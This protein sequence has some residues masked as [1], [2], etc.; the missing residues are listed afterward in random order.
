MG[1]IESERRSR[2]EHGFFSDSDFDCL[3]FDFHRDSSHGLYYSYHYSYYSKF[4]FSDLTD[5]IDFTHSIDEDRF[6][7]A[8]VSTSISIPLDP[9]F[10]P[11]AFRGSSSD[12]RIDTLLRVGLGVGIECPRSAQQ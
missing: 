2:N 7:P 6:L 5:F 1:A 12:P 3:R 9:Y 4:I 10:T 11:S 8:A